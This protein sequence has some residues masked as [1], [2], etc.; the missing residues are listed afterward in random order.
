MLKFDTKTVE[1]CAWVGTGGVIEEGNHLQI[2]LGPEIS[3][4]IGQG[5]YVVAKISVTARSKKETDEY[6][7]PL[8]T[9]FLCL[10][11]NQVASTSLQCQCPD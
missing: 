2:R 4:C 5:D 8:D 1:P 10:I 7:S 6:I 3:S 9:P 11:L